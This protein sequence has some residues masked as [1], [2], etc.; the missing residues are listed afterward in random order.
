VSRTRPVVR[1]FVPMPR[2][3]VQEELAQLGVAEV[4]TRYAEREPT[5]AEWEALQ[6]DPRAGVQAVV[7][8]I[9]TARQREAS[10]SRR[11]HERT[12]YEREL[13]EKGLV[14][15]AGCDEAGVSPLAGPVVAAAA[16]LRK[17]DLIRGVDD[18]KKL[19]PEQRDELAIE[20]KARAVAWA[21][22]LS[23]HL[24]IDTINIYQASL[25]AMRRALEGLS[26]RPEHV[27]LDARRVKEY[28]VPQ[29]PII[30]GDTLSI[31]IGAA[32]ILAKTS[33]DRMLVALDGEYPGYGFAIHKG[34][35][36]AAH[37][38]ALMRLGP[39]PVHRRSFAPVRAAMGDAPK[40]GNLF[41]K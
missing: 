38:E 16:I 3:T 21:V 32:S 34:Y 11:L 29:T 23:T 18:S 22:G 41:G 27:L 33:R 31:T 30:K 4:R 25:Q 2:P 26:V 37:V 7:G 19:S 17:D 12:S 13:W 36:V 15:I 20:I 35:P 5:R 6:A 10:E 1:S 40:Q 14:L 39:C 9:R 24:E 28:P 8:R